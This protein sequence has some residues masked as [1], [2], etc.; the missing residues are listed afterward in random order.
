MNKNRL[1]IELVTA[2]RMSRALW[3]ALRGLA[4]DKDNWPSDEDM[5]AVEELAWQVTIHVER[6]EKLF[7]EPDGEK[8]AGACHA[9]A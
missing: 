4:A 1:E 8:S 6:S 3:L 7:F 5:C 2:S 9:A